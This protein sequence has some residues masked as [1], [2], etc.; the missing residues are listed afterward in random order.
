MKHPIEAH[1]CSQALIGARCDQPLFVTL[2]LFT[3]FGTAILDLF[4]ISIPAFR[5]AG[6][7]LLLFL[8]LEMMRSSGES[9]ADV[10][11]APVKSAMSIAI[12]PLAIPLMAGPGAISTVIIYASVHDSPRHRW[13]VALVVL[14]VAV[15]SCLVLRI[16]TRAEK[17]LHKTALMVFSHIMGLI[18]AAVAVEFILG[19]LIAYM[20]GLGGVLP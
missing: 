11:P 5:I 15:I 12:I 4:A 18:L 10:A 16:S 19:G 6:G 9:S 3:F 14:T 13:L 8:A 2:V 20:P 17:F 1:R 7:I